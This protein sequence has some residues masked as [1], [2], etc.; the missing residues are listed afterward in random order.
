M[1]GSAGS[2]ALESV[3]SEAEQDYCQVGKTLTKNKPEFQQNMQQ[4]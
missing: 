3:C 4:L 2:E 1:S